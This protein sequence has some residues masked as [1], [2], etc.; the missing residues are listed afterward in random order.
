MWK[1]IHIEG[2]ESDIARPP[3]SLIDERLREDQDLRVLFNQSLRV[4]IKFAL[5]R[6]ARV[7]QPFAVEMPA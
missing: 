5:L 3:D 1:T 6:M 2:S 7:S 4:E